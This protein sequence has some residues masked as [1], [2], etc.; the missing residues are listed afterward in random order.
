MQKLSCQQLKIGE[1]V[2]SGEK[3]SKD[4]VEQTASE[5]EGQLDVI[6]EEAKA[7]LILTSQDGEV[8]ESSEDQDSSLVTESLP[9]EDYNSTNKLPSIL[10]MTLDELIAYIEDI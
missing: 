10:D 4:S 8:K 3:Y 6:S 5:S 1:K 2:E 7:E 9:G